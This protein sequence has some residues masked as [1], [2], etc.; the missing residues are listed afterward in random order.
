MVKL[1]AFVFAVL[2]LHHASGEET[3]VEPAEVE[4]DTYRLP[5]AITP[6]NYKLEV[7]THLNDT[8]PFGFSGVVWITVG[9]VTPSVTVS[10]SFAQA[11]MTQTKKASRWIIQFSIQF[12]ICQESH[13]RK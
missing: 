4:Y 10:K 5:T 7:I 1:A 9:L 3:V 2:L 13:K 8:E 12:E 6:E 11:R